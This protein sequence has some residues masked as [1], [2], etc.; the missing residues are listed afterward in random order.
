MNLMPESSTPKAC[1][2]GG[3][4]KNVGCLYPLVM[5]FLALLPMDWF[6]MEISYSA[7]FKSSVLSL[8]ETSLF[9]MHAYSHSFFTKGMKMV[10][11][12]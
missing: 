4:F 1:Q 7:T 2:K 8:Q 11:Y 9:L 6:L 10:K 5:A 12:T 3:V